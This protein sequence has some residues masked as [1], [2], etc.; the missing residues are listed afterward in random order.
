MQS[1]R[2]VL[3]APSALFAFE[4]AARLGSFTRAA[5]ELGV[6]QAAVSYAVKQLESRLGQ[7]L[8]LRQHRRVA[9][10]EAG[11]RF[12]QDVSIGLGHIRR[13]AETLMSRGAAGHVTLSCSTAFASWWMLPRLARFRAANPEID[14]RLQT[15]DKDVDLAA[16]GIDLGIRRGDGA[17]PAYATAFLTPEAIYPICS[18][19]YLAGVTRP[20]SPAALAQLKLVHLDEPFRPRPVW[21]DWFA[22]Q[23]V[24]YVDFGE[25]L[26]LNDYALVIQAALEGQGVALGWR[27]LTEDLVARGALIRPLPQP[28][29]TGLGFYVTWP[30]SAPLAGD[31]ARVRD[32]IAAEFAAAEA[33][34]PPV[35]P[36]SPEMPIAGPR[37]R[38]SRRP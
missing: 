37:L 14:L 15:T 21:A 6:T 1:L 13:S 17:W 23:G 9:L 30:A 22:A 33:L 3:P 5:A 18:P 24:G 8:F 26:R 4:A 27:H 38:V 10:T 36:P 7:P 31:A 12:F 2:A 28:L 19:A 29:V 11:E 34:S 16:E 35:P 25:G 32:W 20:A